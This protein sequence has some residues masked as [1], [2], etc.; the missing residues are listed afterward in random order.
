[1]KKRRK[2]RNQRTVIVDLVAKHG[3]SV[4]F[5]LGDNP[6]TV[7]VDVMNGS[8]ITAFFPE[9]SLVVRMRDSWYRYDFIKKVR[10]YCEWTGITMREEIVYTEVGA[11]DTFNFDNVADQV[12][13]KLVFA[14]ELL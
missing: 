3:L 4:R 1:M 12:I 9:F 7:I 10:E 14:E 5:D 6:R 2:V 8:P 13:I 11:W